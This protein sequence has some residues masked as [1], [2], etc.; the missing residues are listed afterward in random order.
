MNNT[1]QIKKD[2]K[3]FTTIKTIPN[4]SNVVPVKLTPTKG[5]PVRW[6]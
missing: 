3:K 4:L 1:K 5:N 2:V 6:F